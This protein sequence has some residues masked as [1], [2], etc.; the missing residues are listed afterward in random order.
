MLWS[1]IRQRNPLGRAL[2]FCASAAVG[3]P[4]PGRVRLRRYTRGSFLIR[5]PEVAG[6][7]RQIAV[8]I[9]ETFPETMTQPEGGRTEKKGGFNRVAASHWMT[10][11]CPARQ[12]WSEKPETQLV[13]PGSSQVT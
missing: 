10:P 11:D 5:V 4:A 13:A 1:G 9:D 2:T 12:E 7:G 3:S 6:D 8:G